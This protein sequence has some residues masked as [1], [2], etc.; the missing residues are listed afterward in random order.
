MAR[1]VCTISKL[2]EMPECLSELVDGHLPVDS[3]SLSH[4]CDKIQSVSRIYW[5]KNL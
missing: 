3:W 2:I 4:Q 5:G 1:L